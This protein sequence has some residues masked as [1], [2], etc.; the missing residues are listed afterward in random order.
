[1]VEHAIEN[2]SVGGSIPPLGT[3]NPSMALLLLLSAIEIAELIWL[4]VPW[5]ST[6]LRM[7]PTVLLAFML[8]LVTAA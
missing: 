2:R 5:C 3:N 4:Y 1:M 8:A 7:L 6:V